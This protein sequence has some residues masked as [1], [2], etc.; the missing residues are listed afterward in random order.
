MLVNAQ[1]QQIRGRQVFPGLEHLR[2]INAHRFPAILHSPSSS[3]SGPLLLW[4]S[5]GELITSVFF[6]FFFWG[7]QFCDL[8]K[9][10]M[11]HSKQLKNIS[12]YSSGDLLKPCLEI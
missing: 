8:A 12:F 1:V 10:A 7:G 9:V 3:H 6:F 5:I 11:I 4:R 2:A